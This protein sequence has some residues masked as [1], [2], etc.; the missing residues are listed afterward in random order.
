LRVFARG[1]VGVGAMLSLAFAHAQP[2]STKKLSTTS[3]RN[4]PGQQHAVDAALRKRRA[5]IARIL[6][7]YSVP[8]TGAG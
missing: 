4:Y 3:S 8:L 7:E 6:Q 1:R 2:F 5:E